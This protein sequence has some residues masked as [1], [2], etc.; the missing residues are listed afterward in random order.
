MEQCSAKEFTGNL[1]LSEV[2]KRSLALRT[3]LLKHLNSMLA[4]L[5]RMVD[6]S[7]VNEPWS[8]AS[9]LGAMRGL[10]FY[11]VKQ[12]YFRAV[13][14]STQSQLMRPVITLNRQQEHRREVPLFLQGY[15]ALKSVNAAMLRRNDRAFEVK[16]EKEGAQDAGGP[17]QECM[18]QFCEDLRSKELGL[19]TPCPN[20]KEEIGINQDKFVPCAKEHLAQYRFVGMLLGIALRT[21]NS[22]E[23]AL[24]SI[25]WKPLVRQR[26]DRSDLEA[27]DKCCCQFVDSIRNIGKQGVTEETFNDFIFETFTTRTVRGELVELKPGGRSM[28]VMWDNRHEFTSLVEQVGGGRNKKCSSSST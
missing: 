8:I 6:L 10:I 11:G 17:Y 18:T 7:L 12:D 5:V 19:F 23:L 22:L 20:A 9:C 26:L 13:L 2:P 27:I 25:V 14:H 28:S 24:P 1:L 3:V 16:L 15:Q 4:L 21:R